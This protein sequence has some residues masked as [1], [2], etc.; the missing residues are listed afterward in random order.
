LMAQ[1]FEDCNLIKNKY[2]HWKKK[3]KKK[4]MF[5]SLTKY[6]AFLVRFCY[7]L[8]FVCFLCVVSFSWKQLSPYY[9]SDTVLTAINTA[10]EF[11]SPYDLCLVVTT[12]YVYSLADLL[13]N[14]PSAT[15]VSLHLRSL[16]WPHLTRKRQA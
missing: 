5:H 12:M 8:L 13:F 3:K 2:I 11:S 1:R 7:L 14:N 9:V 16:L 15:E 4:E 10:F 6:V